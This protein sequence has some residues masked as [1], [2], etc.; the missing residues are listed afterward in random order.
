MTQISGR[1]YRIVSSECDGVYVGSTTA[2]LKTR[3][4]KHQ[5]HYKRYLYGDG[6]FC[7]SYEI[8]KFTDAKMELVHEGLFDS[9]K[10]MEKFEGDT[11]RTTPNAVNKRL[12]G[13]S[14]QQHYQDNKETA[15]QYSQQYYA[16]KKE[17]IRQHQREYREANR[18]AINKHNNIKCACD[19]CGGKYTLNNT[20]QHL[21]SKKHQRAIS[22]TAS[23]SA[24]NDLP[25][26]ESDQ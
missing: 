14:K 1:I 15:L 16:D 26:S 11:I 7:T 25:D 3:F 6:N 4:C 20:K 9:K 5:N 17:T 10:D 22:S 19:V 24:D 13:R 2:Q 18:D 12:A 8:V 21:G 23:S